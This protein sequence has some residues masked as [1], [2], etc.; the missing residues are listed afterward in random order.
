MRFGWIALAIAAALAAGCGGSED[1][2]SPAS[3]A[4]DREQVA[5]VARDYLE[6]FVGGDGE[7]TCGHLTAGAQEQVKTWTNAASCEDGIGQVGDLIAEEDRDAG[8]R[9]AD[10]RIERVTVTGSKAEAQVETGDGTPRP[11]ALEKVGG[12]WKV[13]GFP[14]GATFRSQA[15]AECVFGGLIQFDE[16]GGDPFWQKEGREDFQDFIVETCRRADEQGFLD[17]SGNKPQIQRI[18]GQVLLKMVRR[19]QVRDPR[20]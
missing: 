2:S 18:A 10:V 1:E 16:G 9:V 5:A 19:G 12:T 4:S 20:R 8:E 7:R 3:G 6:A 15:H 11:V 14:P 13:A 17:E